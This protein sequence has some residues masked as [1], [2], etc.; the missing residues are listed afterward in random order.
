MFENTTV[1]EAAWILASVVLI[2]AV[3]LFYSCIIKP[4]QDAK[5]KAKQERK[6]RAENDKLFEDAP[7]GFLQR[8]CS[9]RCYKDFADT[10]IMD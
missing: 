3:L 1:Q 8:D 2:F 5:N 4:Y 9:Q 10:P 7:T 6:E